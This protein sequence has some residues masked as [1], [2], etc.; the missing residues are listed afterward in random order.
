VGPDVLLPTFVSLRKGTGISHDYDGVR[1]WKIAIE[2]GDIIVP[3]LLSQLP[4]LP[5]TNDNSGFCDPFIVSLGQGH[6][7]MLIRAM[8]GM[9]WCDSKE[10]GRAGTWGVPYQPEGVPKLKNVINGMMVDHEGDVVVAHNP[11]RGRMQG[12]LTIYRKDGTRASVVF[13]PREP[14]VGTHMA[15]FVL[16][17]DRHPDGKPTGNYIITYDHGR[18]TKVAG[19]AADGVNFRGAICTAI[20]P[21]ASVLAGT[22]DGVV[23]HDVPTHP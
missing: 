14:P 19:L 20:V 9:Y 12:A 16:S 21:K 23:I 3:E 17:I 2:E 4:D 11:T 5:D 13:D 1:L 6:Y 8:S 22:R 10:S 18:N 15:N 7:R